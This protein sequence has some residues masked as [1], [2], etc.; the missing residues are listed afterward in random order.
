MF[1]A[2]VFALTG[3]RQLYFLLGDLFDRLVYL[4]Y[5]IAF[6]L[7]FIG[8]KLLLHALHNNEVFSINGGQH[9]EWAPEIGTFTS[10]GVIVGAMAVAVVASLIAVRRSATQEVDP[11]PDDVEETLITGQSE[12]SSLETPMT[13]DPR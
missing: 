5:G 2:N 3:L 4:T 8:V 7:A 6:V 11:T 12:R 10:L 13:R 9:V 1:A